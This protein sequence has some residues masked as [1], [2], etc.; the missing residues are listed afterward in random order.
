MQRFFFFSANISPSG[1]DFS[2][3]NPVFPTDLM[4]MVT[5]TLFPYFVVVVVVFICTYLFLRVI[6]KLT[7][8]L[9]GHSTGTETVQTLN[10]RKD[11]LLLLLILFYDNKT[12]SSH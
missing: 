5:M 12:T 1:S 8:Q 2:S 6:L 11:F 3:N 7:L 4:F 9:L 10:L